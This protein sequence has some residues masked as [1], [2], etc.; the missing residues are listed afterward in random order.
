MNSEELKR[1]MDLVNAERARLVTELPA[2][3]PERY[4]EL[5]VQLTDLAR[6]W[7]AAAEHEAIRR[8]KE[9]RQP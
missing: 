2:G 6:R 4:A 1:E 9:G 7:Q 3:W 5:G 8:W